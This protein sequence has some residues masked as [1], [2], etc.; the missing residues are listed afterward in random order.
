MMENNG[1]HN[2]DINHAKRQIKLFTLP[3]HCISIHQTNILVITTKLKNMDR[4]MT[5][6]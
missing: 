5:S 1:P 3:P 2:E 6:R 4:S